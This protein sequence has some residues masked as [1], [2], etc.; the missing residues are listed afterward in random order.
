MRT[1]ILFLCGSY[2]LCVHNSYKPFMMLFGTMIDQTLVFDS[3]LEL[4][5]RGWDEPK[6]TADSI[7]LTIP[8]SFSWLLWE[9]AVYFGCNPLYLDWSVWRSECL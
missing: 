6:E 5:G 1:G 4:K 8:G 7:L 9:E 2:K 3:S